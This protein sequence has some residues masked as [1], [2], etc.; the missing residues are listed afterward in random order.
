MAARLD[1]WFDREGWREEARALR[2][3]LL[4]C[5]LEEELKW[6]QPCYTHES[7]NIAIIGRMKDA[8]WLSFFKG[9][10]LSD[11]EGILERPGENSHAARRIRFTDTAGIEVVADRIAAFVHEA[12]AAEASGRTVEKAGDIVL[13]GELKDALATDPELE[14]AFAALTPGRQRSYNIHVSG[15][16]QAATR[17]SRI[18]KCRG[19]I[20]AGKGFNER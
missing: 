6:R 2:R 3:I 1:P 13:V 12:I 4:G 8:I 17:V 9:S 20:L 19:K 18:E 10:L 11:P 5:G 14:A 16:K 7:R 15:A